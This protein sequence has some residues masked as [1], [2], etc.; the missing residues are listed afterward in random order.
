MVVHGET[1]TTTAKIDVHHHAVG[2]RK[3]N[4]VISG[5]RLHFHGMYRLVVV[6]D[7]VLGTRVF[8][9]HRSLQLFEK[10]LLARSE[11]VVVSS[12][13][14]VV[15]VILREGDAREIP[16]PRIESRAL[17]G[18][19]HQEVRIV[20]SAHQLGTVVN[21]N[22]EMTG[23]RLGE[24]MIDQMTGLTVSVNQTAFEETHFHL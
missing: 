18:A 10:V 5:T 14:A 24:M 6:E 7:A 4:C 23:A 9:A 1:A 11:V 13:E 16:L 20:G 3:L 17:G 15:E 2:H 22:V 19:V 21:L 12:I 8:Q